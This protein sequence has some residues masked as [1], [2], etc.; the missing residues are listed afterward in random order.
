MPVSIWV[1]FLFSV[2]IRKEVICSLHLCYLYFVLILCPHIYMPFIYLWQTKF[3]D[4][5]DVLFN[6]N[7]F[8]SSSGMSIVL[9][10][11]SN[12]SFQNQLFNHNLHYAM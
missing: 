10:W 1:C 6:I 8:L 2:K 3:I 5:R 9:V 7:E 4:Q 12:W 11:N